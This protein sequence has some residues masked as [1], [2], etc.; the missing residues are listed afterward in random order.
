[1]VG[2]EVLMM[3]V[4]AHT[5]RDTRELVLS[6]SLSPPVRIQKE[7]SHRQGRKEELSP[8]TNDTG[9]LVLD[10]QLP[11]LWEAVSVIWAPQSMVFCY[12]VQADYNNP[13]VS[14]TLALSSPLQ[15]K[16][17]KYASSTFSYSTHFINPQT[18]QGDNST[19]ERKFKVGH[20]GQ[21]CAKT[22]WVCPMGK[23]NVEQITAW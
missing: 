15:P 16:L 13:T 2:D 12:P 11:E 21:H 4:S 3:V 8:E 9:T 18:S 22:D 10:F 17:L 5:R 6:L 14:F 23:T 19:E 7:G 1:M 20:T